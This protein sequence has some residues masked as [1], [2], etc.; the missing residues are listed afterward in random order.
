MR[1]WNKPSAENFKTALFTSPYSTPP[2]LIVG[3]SELDIGTEGKICANTYAT[4]VQNDHFTIHLNS[5]GNK[6][7]H[8]GA[9]TWLEIAENDPDFQFG[10]FSTLEDHPSTAPQ[11]YTSRVI[12]FPRVYTSPPQVVVWLTAFDLGRDKVF[13]V[14]TFATDITPTSFTIHINTWS[15]SIL[16]TATSSWIAYP[17]D[18]PGIF[19]GTFNTLNVR[20]RKEHQY[21]NTAYVNFG[22]NVFTA[23]PRTFL[24][25]NSL[26]M[27]QK[28]NLRLRTWASSVTAT[29]MTWHIE[30][31]YNTIL[32][33]AGVSYIAIA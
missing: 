30:G 22:S 32:Y 24:V 19:G 17:S 28:T 15:D 7:M 10:K 3:L 16:F 9:C 21:H 4:S 27:S 1:P 26:D 5:V 14:R 20:S 29:G 6:T 23:P 11:V 31:W 25:F 8:G 2:N 13:R 12:K 18:K 33:S